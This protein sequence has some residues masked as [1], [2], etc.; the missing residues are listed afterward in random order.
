MYT[1]IYDVLRDCSLFGLAKQGGDETLDLFPQIAKSR[2]Q[3]MID[4]WNTLKPRMIEMANG[5]KEYI[6]L[7][8][9]FEKEMATTKSG[10]RINPM[11]SS[12]KFNKFRPLLQ[13]ITLT[14]LKMTDPEMAVRDDVIFKAGEFL[15]EDFR[16]MLDF[17]NRHRIEEEQA[18]GLGDPT[19]NGMYGITNKRK[20]KNPSP[21][22][23]EKIGELVELY[24]IIEGI[25][26]SI[27]GTTKKPPNL[28]KVANANMTDDSTVSIVESYQTFVP[29]PFEISLQHMARKY[30]GS[31]DRWYE[32]VT[33]NSLQSPYVDN[34][35]T[36]IM[37]SAPASFNTV[38]VDDALKT[39]VAPGVKIGI[40]SEKYPEEIRQIDRISIINGKMT[41][42]LGGKNDLS[43]ITP[44][45][46]G[47]IR[48]YQPSTVRN[49]SFIM[50]PSV[51]TAVVPSKKTPD[52]GYLRNLDRAFIQFGIDIKRDE[53]TGDFVISQNGDF[54]LAYGFPAVRQ[55][56]MNA[57]RTK[58]GELP[59]HPG[60]G[61]NHDV[62]YRFFGTVDEAV[63]FADAITDALMSDERIAD[64]KIADISALN[65]GIALKILVKIKGFDQFIPLAFVS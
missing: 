57:L 15:E 17:V 59:F 3:W 37:L 62:G 27:Q 22:D 20:Q 7:V 8:S 46:K 52:K 50:I 33:V 2:W 45:Q 13:E 9:D 10:S 48:I 23:M 1:N 63:I 65:T 53:R 5:V 43:K 47:Y 55:A 54:A 49:N 42:V 44:L 12:F 29:V 35:G 36:K 31:V 30:L 28:L 56:V 34:V 26:F 14:E 19:V 39:D 18:L 32:L 24:Q 16:K 25:I 41:L 61:V 11:D 21:S 6:D 58:M 51:N 40:G 60:Y 64:I 38:T 4:N